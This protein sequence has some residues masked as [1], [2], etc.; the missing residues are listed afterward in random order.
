MKFFH[1]LGLFTALLG[2]LVGCHSD[3]A[4]SEGAD[5]QERSASEPQGE[6]WDNLRSMCGNAYTGAV[7]KDAP[8]QNLGEPEPFWSEDDLLMDVHHCTS[9]TVRIAFHA[10]GVR[11]R[12]FVF[13]RAEKGILFQDDRRQRDGT[14][15]QL[16]GY[17]GLTWGSGSPQRQEFP[18]DEYSLSLFPRAE[19]SIWTF[20]IIPNELWAYQYE[21]RK[22]GEYRILRVEF[23]LADT[24][25]QPPPPWGSS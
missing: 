12:S 17:G 19:G 10:A 21:L 4:P 18:I 14:P 20:D 15:Q 1:H 22:E 3:P 11:D 2:L 25:P 13:S 5:D 16:T 9:D 7:V 6:Y 24:V 23:G 8:P